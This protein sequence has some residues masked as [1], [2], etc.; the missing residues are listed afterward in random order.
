LLPAVV[1]PAEVR[2]SIEHRIVRGG[3]RTPRNIEFSGTENVF[4]SRLAAPKSRLR[5]SMQK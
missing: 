3:L 4:A 5:N 1:N 2:H